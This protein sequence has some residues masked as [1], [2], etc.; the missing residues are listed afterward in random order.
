[1]RKAS[2][3]CGD[4]GEGSHLFYSAGEEGSGRG[5]DRLVVMVQLEGLNHYGEGK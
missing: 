4:L 5:G 2:A 1:V 3:R